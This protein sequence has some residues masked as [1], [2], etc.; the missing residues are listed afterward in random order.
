M[1]HCRGIGT[2]TICPIIK[3]KV[4]FFGVATLSEAL[5][6]REFDKSSKIL[7]L[8][9][10]D[11]EDI[12]ICNKNNISISVTSLDYLF[13]VLKYSNIKIHLQI[14]TGLNRFG[15]RSMSKFKKAISLIEK[16]NCNLEGVYS[17]FATKQNDLQF[18]KQQFYKYLQFK[19]LCNVKNV[20]FHISNSFGVIAS[21]RYNLNMV[22]T[23]MLMY[24][25]AYYGINNKLVLSIKSKVLAIQYIKKGETIGYD[26][27]FKSDKNMKIAVVGIGY[28]DGLDRRLSNNFYVLIKGKKCKIVGNICMDVLMV[29]VNDIN[30][31]VGDEVTIIGDDNGEKITIDDMANAINASPYELLCRLNSKRM[32]KVVVSS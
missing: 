13:E 7:V 25:G 6:I 32:L 9:V 29:E 18:M 17:H 28:A 15:F 30:V 24:G 10:V 27:T 16:S 23:G 8:G 26:R 3:D 11:I 1:V 19:K 20:L 4:D 12:E 22:R 14:N 2:D 31:F 21:K 5:K